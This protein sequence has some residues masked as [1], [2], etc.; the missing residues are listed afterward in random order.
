MIDG[1]YTFLNSIGFKDPLHA[2]LTHIPIGLIFGAFVFAIIAIKYKKTEF[3]LTARH[4]S[5]LAF[6]MIF[7][8][9][10]FGIFDWQHFYKGAMLQPVKIKMMLAVIVTLILGFGV[11]FGNRLKLKS[12][13]H[14]LIYALSFFCVMGLGFFGGS[15]VYNRSGAESSAVSQ[16]S[17]AK[18]I[19]AD[20]VLKSGEIAFNNNCSACHADGGNVINPRRLLKTSNDLAS[21]DTL[22]VF[23]RTE[24]TKVLRNGNPSEMPVF[25]E[26]DVSKAQAGDLYLYIKYM[27][28]NVWK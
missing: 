8:T 28:S 21:A 24:G 14:T 2:P 18:E 16:T 23:I 5:I 12:T 20:P 11:I 26:K 17:A 1:L 19:Q 6:I 13:T 7:P 15:L 22:T 27:I 4:A 10:L 25:A 9:I 3:E